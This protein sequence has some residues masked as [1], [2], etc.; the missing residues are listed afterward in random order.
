MK[1]K[2]REK[3]LLSF[4]ISSFFS[5]TIFFFGPAHLYFTNIQEY[6][7]PFSQI[8]HFFVA[9]SA[10]SILLLTIFLS[11][12]EA[13][14]HQKAISFFLVLSCLLWL[15]G[16]IFVWDS[17]VLDGRQIIWSGNVA[18]G[19]IGCIIWIPFL[20]VAIAAPV[21]FWKIAQQAGAAFILI[22]SISLLLAVV[23]VPEGPSLLGKDVV[24][25]KP[26]YRFSSDK[27]VIMLILDAFQSDIFQEIINEEP[28]YG[29]FFDGFTYYRNAVGGYAST[30]ASV[31]LLLSGRFYENSIPVQDFIKE[32]FSSTS[33]PKVLTDN[34]YRVDLINGGVCV[35][36]DE[37]IAASRPEISQ[38]IQQKR[39]IEEV[40]FILDL[41]LFRYLPYVLKKYIYND[42]SWCLSNVYSKMVSKESVARDHWSIR[43]WESI[44][45]VRRMVR[46]ATADSDRKTFK[47]VHLVIPH[48]P[49]SFNERLEY[50]KMEFTREN[51]KRQAKGSLN[52]VHTLLKKMIEIG[53]YDN[54]MIL[55]LA[56]TGLGGNIAVD[57]DESGYTENANYQFLKVEQAKAHALPLFLVKPFMARGRLKISDAPV[58]HADVAKTIVSE[59][60]LETDFAGASI[61]EI[62]GSG[63][64]NRRFLLYDLVKMFN[65]GEI[66]PPMEE[67][68][69]SGFSWLNESW[70]P[71]FNVFSSDGVSYIPPRVYK[72]GETITFGARGNYLQYKGGGWSYPEKNFTWTDAGRASIV[73]PVVGGG[74]SDVELVVR[75]RPFIMA[76]KIDRQRV[77][78]FL[79]GRNLCEWVFTEGKLHK[80]HIFIP[81]DLMRGDSVEISFELPDAAS[82]AKLG[83]GEDSRTLGIRMYSLVLNESASRSKM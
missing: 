36:A 14:Y 75:L 51:Y 67:Y 49:V 81:G 47:Y 72:Y 64:R 45:F 19:L 46:E 10:C 29:E 27:N 78:I 73:I 35:Y 59:L 9:A 83:V 42:Q 32:T 62:K 16:N 7:Y 30:Y 55:I 74:E 48:P 52:L 43:Q 34:G 25:E 22:Q 68:M 6:S 21:R 4:W 58:S 28:S 23:Q 39:K 44:E 3:L 40:T 31:A 15:Q 76:G 70:N 79:S 2:T 8:W 60:N 57:V 77:R 61:F 50:K 41:T 66:F 11:S 5:L 1:E 56:D 33:I 63:D 20:I 24:D 53:V 12:L 17:G 80:Q 69:V 82:P 26:L 18:Y 71:T 38:I 13:Q 65:F 37:T 54:T